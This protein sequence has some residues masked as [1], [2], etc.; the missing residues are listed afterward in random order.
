MDAGIGRISRM[1]IS[2]RELTATHSG[3]QCT[4]MGHVTEVSALRRSLNG[5]TPNTSTGGVLTSTPASRLNISPRSSR[6]TCFHS[7]ENS[8]RRPKSS[9][10]FR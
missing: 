9:S 7:Y 4:G 2:P 8:F 5:S 1:N 6:V 3:A 10:S